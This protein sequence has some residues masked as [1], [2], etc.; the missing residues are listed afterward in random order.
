[1]SSARQILESAANHGLLLRFRHFD[2]NHWD[3]QYYIRFRHSDA[4][5][6]ADL[7]IADT[8]EKKIG[9]ISRVR[10][11]RAVSTVVSLCLHESK[12]NSMSVM[13]QDESLSLSF[14]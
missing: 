11:R 5:D 10:Y 14:D 7:E 6:M 13:D 3:I 2:G 9:D 8:Y 12:R 4:P 1:M